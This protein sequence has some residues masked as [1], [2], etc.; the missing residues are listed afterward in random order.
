MNERQI[1]TNNI[2]KYFETNKNKK[3][4]I[5]PYRNL[6]GVVSDILNDE[7]GIR[8]QFIVDNYACDMEHIYPMNR[9]PDGYE[10]CTFMLAAFGGTKK[11]LH[12]MLLEYVSEDRI[13][14]LL[15]DENREKVFQSDSKVHMDFLCP[16]FTKC[17]TTSMHYALA[18]NPKIFL[19]KVKETYF[20][21]YAVDEKAHEAFKN[22]YKPEETAGRIVGDIEP[23]YKN[24]AEDVH[25]YCGSDLKLI[26]CVRNPV[27]VLY[28][29]YKMEMRNALFMLEAS[30]SGTE[31]NEWDGNV[32]PELFDK[33]AVKYS[34]R[35]RYS[36]YINSYLKYYPMEQIKII[37]GEELYADTKNAMDDLQSF[38][39]IPEK[40]KLEYREF[41]RENIGSKVAKDQIGLEIN[42]NIQQLRYKLIQKGDFQSLDL[43]YSIRDKIEE[44]TLVDYN[45]PMLESTRQNLL[46]YYMDSI[47]DLE[48]M[49]GRSL[50]GVWY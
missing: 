8:E 25:R 21:N 13:V 44:L 50:Q 41:P 6:S 27:D 17:G 29:Y 46:D 14:D 5:L 11:V 2:Y 33:W 24:M 45:E 20:L 49:L 34:F 26:F 39:G 38:L 32:S 40:D 15:F 19:P 43:L 23:G 37:V 48:G 10:E 1:I 35:G 3:I 18:Q 9:M 7:Y 31:S 4:V 36:D 30:T 12:E 47:H 22:H 16:G 42:K 28:S